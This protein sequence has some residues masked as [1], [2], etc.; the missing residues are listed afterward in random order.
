MLDVRFQTTTLWPELIKFLTI[1]Q[2]MVPK[3]RKP[4]VKPDGLMFFDLS[5]SETVE[6]SISGVSGRTRVVGRFSNCET[7]LLRGGGGGEYVGLTSARTGDFFTTSLLIDERFWRLAGG[8]FGTTSLV[9]T[10][11]VAFSFTFI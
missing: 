2:P 1:P 6:T 3:P 8:D 5:V 10:F 4:N 9:S 11:A 7:A